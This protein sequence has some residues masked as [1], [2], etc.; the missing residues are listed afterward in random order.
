MF[1]YS[2]IEKA[3]FN[4]D[5]ILSLYVLP[6]NENPNQYVL[7]GDVLIDNAATYSTK[8]KFAKV[9]IEQDPHEFLKNSV[10]NLNLIMKGE[11]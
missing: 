10:N 6:D 9:P 7:C 3:F 11:H 4:S 2:R 1:V 5:F 8:I